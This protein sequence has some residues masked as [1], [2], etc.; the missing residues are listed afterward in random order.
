MAEIQ[1]SSGRSRTF[2]PNLVPFID[3]MSVLITFLLIT[4]VWTQ[5]SIIQ[6]GTSLYSKK[7]PSNLDVT[8]PPKAE[9]PLRLDILKTGY[10]LI[11]A[12][13]R[14][15]IPSHDGARLTGHLERVKS[16]YPDKDDA[17]IAMQD[18]LPYDLLI[19]GMDAFL[20]AGFNNISIL[21]GGPR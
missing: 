3:L 9:I 10:R 14:I 11:V 13:E 21:T 6:M 16:L 15:E 17:A 12:Q 1:D 4:A 19:K 8:I 5:V 2:E 20:A 18:E 7:D